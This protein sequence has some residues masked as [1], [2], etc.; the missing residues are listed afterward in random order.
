MIYCDIATYHRLSLEGPAQI[1]GQRICVPVNADA[2]MIPEGL[3][4][5]L[6]LAVFGLGRRRH[7]ALAE[8]SIYICIFMHVHIIY[9]YMFIYMLYVIVYI[10]ICVCALKQKY[11]YYYYIYIIVVYIYIY[12]R[13]CYYILYTI[14][15]VPYLQESFIT[16][17]TFGDANLFHQ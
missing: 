9:F 8:C 3:G 12:I 11:R 10:Y 4:E 7:L 6:I 5:L 14:A 17:I 15:E 2:Q 1:N 16:I 13:I